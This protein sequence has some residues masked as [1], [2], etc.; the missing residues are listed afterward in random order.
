MK[1]IKISCV[2]RSGLEV[3][4]RICPAFMRDGF[5]VFRKR[6]WEREETCSEEIFPT[7][8]AAINRYISALNKQASAGLVSRIILT[9]D[10]REESK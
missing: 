5:R 6:E 4:Y 2:D 8:E 10:K 3:T 1:D 9:I 7:E